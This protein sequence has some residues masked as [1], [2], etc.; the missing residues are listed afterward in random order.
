MKFTFIGAGAIGGVVGAY[1]AKAGEDVTLVDINEAHIKAIQ[2]KGLA[3]ETLDETFVVDV[4]AKTVNELL[5]EGGELDVVV[6]A[7]KAQHTQAAVENI[8][9]LLTENSVVVSMQNGLTENVIAE[10]IG[11]ERTIGSFVN[12]FADYQEPGLIQYGGV[13]AMYIGELDGAR[14]DRIVEIERRLQAWGNAEVTDNIYGY[15]WSKLA[16]G[17]ILTATA[18][19]DEKM[20]D[21]LDPIDNREMFVEVAT[22]VLKVAEKVGV[23]PLGF[24][25]WEPNT[26]YPKGKERDWDA[27]NEQFDRI[28]GLL[29]TYKKVKTGIWRDLAVHKRKTEVPFHLGPVIEKGEKF[30]LDM[31]LT[32]KI[33]DMIVELEEGRREMT[34]ENIEELKTLSEEKYS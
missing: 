19:V 1:L 7:V 26:V 13:G 9:P 30:G 29:R 31:T 20:A 6:L 5:D 4:K 27:I 8:V 34:K 16:Y 18:T 11:E 32:Q 17:A 28:V 25:N 2:D 24:N 33:L 3:I 15:L 10:I 14:T 12:L 22:E 21:T 23:E